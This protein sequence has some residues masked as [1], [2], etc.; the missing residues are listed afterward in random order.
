MRS[1]LLFL[2]F[3]QQHRAISQPLGM[4]TTNQNQ[5][6][7]PSTC[8]GKRG[9]WRGMVAVIIGVSPGYAVL[10]ALAPFYGVI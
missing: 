7:L 10:I 9:A 6:A 4:V 8:G 5:E 1:S 3:L 2:R